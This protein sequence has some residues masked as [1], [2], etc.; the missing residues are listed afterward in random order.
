VQSP[1]VEG[2]EGTKFIS[3]EWTLVETPVNGNT[4]V[5]KAPGSS[6]NFSAFIDNWNYD[7]EDATDDI[8]S[9]AFNVE[10]ADSVIINWDLAHKYYPGAKNDTFSIISSSDCGNTFTNILYNAGGA[11]LAT[12]GSGLEYLTPLPEDWATRRVALG[13]PALANGSLMILFRNKNEYGNNIF[14]DNI[15]IE[16]LFFRDL[17]VI[18]IDNP[19]FIECKSNITAKATVKNKGLEPITGFTISYKI[20]NGAA[21]TTSFTGI[22]LLRD[23]TMQ[24]MLSPDLSGLAG[25]HKITI[26]SSSPLTTSGNTDQLTTNDTLSKNFGISGAA[27]PPFTENFELSGFP[28][29]GWVSVNP[30]ANIGWEK[31]L[32]G[33]SSASSAFIDNFNYA[34]AGRVDDLYSPIINYTGVDS[35]TLSFDLAAATR[36]FP[37]TTTNP[38]DTFEVLITKDCGNSFTTI[39]KKWGA[40]LQTLNDPNTPQT[41]EFIPQADYL[42]RKEVIDLTGGFIPDGPIQLVFRNITNK[43][44]NIFIDNVNLTTRTLPTRLKQEGWLILPNP[45]KDQFNIWHL[46]QPTNLRYITIYNSAGQMIWKQEYNNNARK[47]ITVDMRGQAAGIYIVNM[48]Y[49]DRKNI[50]VKIINL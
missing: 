28:P 31:A 26:Y 30:D 47:L 34:F 32:T 23:S 1:V 15:D 20:D 14:L 11:Q 5:R 27:S 42:W 40:E 45:F 48:G 37:G 8:I 36:D 18:S 39:Y 4:W 13:G 21:Q 46:Q 43:G 3:P 17:A 12:A 35:V 10:G 38:L 16:G 19:N 9:P 24:V 49:A 2:F 44:N 29:T 22:N 25:L 6:S 33:K 50:R 41:I 7:Q